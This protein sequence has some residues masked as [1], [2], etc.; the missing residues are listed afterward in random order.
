[1]ILQLNPALPLFHPEKGNFLAHLVLDYGQE[2]YVYFCGFVESTG[3]IWTFSNRDLRAQKN[4]TLGR[5]FKNE[6]HSN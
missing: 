2:S 1:M 3:E 5:D 6:L 4:I